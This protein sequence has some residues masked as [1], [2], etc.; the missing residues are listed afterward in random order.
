[1]PHADVVVVMQACVV[2]VIGDEAWMCV[3]VNIFLI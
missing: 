2:M 1:M 3:P